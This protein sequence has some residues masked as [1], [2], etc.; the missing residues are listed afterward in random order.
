MGELNMKDIERFREILRDSNNIVFFGGAGVSTNSN[1]PDFRS[2]DGIYNKEYDIN[3]APEYL[4]SHTF[5]EKNPDEFS[6]YYKEKLIHLDAK[7]NYAH[8]ALAELEKMGKLKAVITQNID[9]LH[10]LAGSKNVL[11]IHGTLSR[12]YC[13]ECG[14]EFSIEYV[15]RNIGLSKCSLCGGVVRPDVVLYEEALNPDV[16]NAAVEY[17]KN[18]DTMIVAGSS[19]VVYPAA[20]L[21]RYFNG[22]NLIIINKDSTKYDRYAEL[23][24]HD[25]ICEVFEEA[26]KFRDQPAE[27]AEKKA[28]EQTDEQPEN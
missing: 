11:E 20:G 15:M 5:F 27:D 8:I 18:A 2:D 19:L 25:D 24:F 23:V 12:H 6:R 9:N 13:T 4:L 14:K 28:E 7:P 16:L 17:V 10:Q 26:M 1:I 3:Y 22:K 21:V